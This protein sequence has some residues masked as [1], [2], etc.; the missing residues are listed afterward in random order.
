[1][2]DTYC[3]HH[4][5]TTQ[6]CAGTHIFLI[7]VNSV[8]HNSKNKGRKL[9]L[10][11]HKSK[12]NGL[13]NTSLSMFSSFY[14]S[15]ITTSVNFVDLVA[16]ISGIS[17]GLH[18]KAAFITDGKVVLAIKLSVHFRISLNFGSAIFQTYKS[19]II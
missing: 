1:M 10:L 2:C 6:Q 3:T 16:A 17:T 9:R 7:D 15:N 12:V 14:I 4:D 19:F 18:G 13:H 11:N 8:G 5:Q